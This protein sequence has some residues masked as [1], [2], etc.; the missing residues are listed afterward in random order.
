MTKSRH[1]FHRNA[2]QFSQKICRRAAN[3]LKIGES[4]FVFSLRRSKIWTKKDKNQFLNRGK[5]GYFEEIV[6]SGISKEIS[7]SVVY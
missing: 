4:L 6:T 7:F 3:M 1:Y 5:V 2:E